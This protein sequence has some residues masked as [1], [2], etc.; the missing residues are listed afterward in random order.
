MKKC[1]LKIEKFK[2]WD[3]LLKNLSIDQYLEKDS[4]LGPKE[5][6]QSSTSTR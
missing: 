3:S 6:G 4:A 5:E 1:C 2:I